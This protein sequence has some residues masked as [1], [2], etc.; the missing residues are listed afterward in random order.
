MDITLY[1]NQLEQFRTSLYQNFNN[2]ADT[3]MELVDAMSS[4]PD[5]K[6]VVAYSLAGCFRR[7]YSTM[8][9]AIAEMKLASMWLAEQLAGSLMQPQVWPFWLLMVDVTPNPR[10]YARTLEDRGMVYQPEVVK[11]KLPVTI[12]HQYSTVALGLEPEAGISSSWVLPL[13]TSRV[14]TDA[15]K[16]Q[17]GMAQIEQLLKNE[18]LPFGK[19][20]TVEV[21]DSSYSKPASLYAHRQYPNLVTIVRARGTRTFYH[22]PDASV[23]VGANPG[24]GH[25]TW[26]GAPFSLA[27]A[28]IQTPPD[29]T[30]TVWE[31]S[32]RGKQYRVEIQAWHQMLMPG[33]RKPVL[34]PMH[35]HPFTL[36]RIVRYDHAGQP[37]FKHPLWLIVMGQRRHELTL[38]H[39]YQAY[40]A[41]FDMEHFFRFGKQ[42]LLLVGFQTPEVAHEENWFQLAHIAYAQL[43]MARHLVHCLPKPWERTLPTIRRRLI[44]PTLVQRDFDRIIRQLG[45]PAQPPK[46]RGISP[47]RRKGV[48]LPKRLRK[49]VVVKRL[50]ATK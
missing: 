24:Q 14:A 17:V 40:A 46:P 13:L 48:K 5:A 37:A 11:G 43:W 41:R 20:L 25:P 4:T 1:P 12:G 32:R 3:L 29:E 23:D 8:F 9:K 38:T 21:A 35:Q 10:P 49:K 27:S 2:R 22:Q 31:T 34:L 16:E 19:A 33:E 15:D 18:K 6:S 50:S 44:S 26:Y 30:Q 36:V 39:I 7:S 47:G 28:A 42:K 45:T